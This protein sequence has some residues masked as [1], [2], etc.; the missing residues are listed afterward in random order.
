MA[1][2]TVDGREPRLGDEVLEMDMLDVLRIY[3]VST[4]ILNHNPYT[5]TLYLLQRD[6]LGLHHSSQQPC[7]L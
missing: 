3:L 5:W 4:W 7:R 6:L 1:L 2:P